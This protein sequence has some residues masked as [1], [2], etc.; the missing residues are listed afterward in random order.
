[1]RW[2]IVLVEMAIPVRAAAAWWAGKRSAVGGT[3]EA[4]L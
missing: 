1:M 3:A 4:L 2:S